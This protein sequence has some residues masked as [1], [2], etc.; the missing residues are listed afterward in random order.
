[1]ILSA[2]PLLIKSLTATV[3]KTP[4][5]AFLEEH[6]VGDILSQFI[7]RDGQLASPKIAQRTVSLSLDELKHKRQSILAAGGIEK[8]P[9]IHAALVG[10]YANVLITDIRSAEKLLEM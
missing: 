3:N 1:M 9:A 6:A 8:V 10:G 2:V 7:D 4:K 5:C